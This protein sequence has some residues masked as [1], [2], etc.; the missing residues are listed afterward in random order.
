[1][2]VVDAAGGRSKKKLPPHLIPYIQNDDTGF[3]L[4]LRRGILKL[5]GDNQPSLQLHG[6]NSGSATTLRSEPIIWDLL[7]TAWVKRSGVSVWAYVG[8]RALGAPC[9]DLPVTDRDPRLI[10]TLRS[11]VIGID[12]LRRIYVVFDVKEDYG[13]PPNPWLVGVLN[14]A[15]C[16]LQIPITLDINTFGG[17]ANHGNS[18]TVDASGNVFQLHASTDGLRIIRWVP[19]RK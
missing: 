16:S 12:D 14:L 7:K 19:P 1:V 13:A 9:E 4:A 8:L 10:G 3:H 6:S 11:S 15:Q 17:G 2:V 18:L 5:R